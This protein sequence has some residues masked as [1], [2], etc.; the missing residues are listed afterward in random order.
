MVGP[1][2]LPP[3]AWPRTAVQKLSLTSSAVHFQVELVEPPPGA[4][5]GDRVSAAGFEGEPDEVLNPKKKVFEAVQ[6]DLK[7][8]E[9]REACYKEVPLAT[10]Q[11]PC[12]VA[13]I[14]GGSIK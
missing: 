12:T 1:D 4:S 5:V 11:G 9:Q 13:T 8:N 7:T 14:V 2:A 10:S 6:P 3:A